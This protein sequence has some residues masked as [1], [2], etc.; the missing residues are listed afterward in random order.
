MFG[1]EYIYL[2]NINWYN[3]SVI[4]V[5]SKCINAWIYAWS[6]ILFHEFDAIWFYFCAA[7]KN[8]W[9]LKRLMARPV[10]I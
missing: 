7:S 1:S 9:N 8:F 2:L 10:F 3:F 5:N 4:K 6:S